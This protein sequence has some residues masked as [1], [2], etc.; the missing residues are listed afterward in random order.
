MPFWWNRRRR[1]FYPRRNW[2]KTRYY[3][4]RRKRPIRRRRRRIPRR[5]RRRR[6]RYK[7]RRKK[8]TLTVKQWQPDSIVTCKIKG[9]GCLVLGAEGKQ[10]YCY[11]TVKQQWTPAKTPGGGGFGVEVFTLKYLYEE[12]QFRHNVWTKSNLFKDLCRYLRCKFT[13]YRHQ[14][15]D[16]II[17][18]E[19]QP[20]FDLN[21]FTY[22]NMHPIN[23]LLAPHKRILLSKK[24]KPNGK[25]KISIIIKP[26]K[27]M[28]TKWFF[29]DSFSKAPL[30]LIKATAAN[31]SY[32][33]LGC[34]NENQIITFAYINTG[35]YTNPAWGK[36][37]SCD[38]KPYSTAPDSFTVKYVNGS[39][40]TVTIGK[41]KVGISEGYFQPDLLKAVQILQGATH[42]AQT[43]LN[44]ARYNVTLDTGKNNAIWLMSTLAD[45]YKKP[46]TDDIII[47]EGL[48]LYMALNGWL[49]FITTMKNTKNYLD[50]YI[51]GIQSPAIEPYAQHGTLNWYIPISQ[52]FINGTGPYGGYVS[53][54]RKNLWFPQVHSQLEVLNSI[55]EAS[56]FVPKYSQDKQSTWELHYFYQFLFKWGGPQTTDPTVADP[57]KQGHYDVPDT[58]YSS[59][60]I[61][62]PEKQTAPS[63]L[64]SWDY[65]RGFITQRALKRMSSNIQTDTTFQ[66]DSET[67]S[68]KKKRFQGPALQ[69]PDQDFQKTKSCLLSLCESDT[70]QEI[71]EN[72]DLLHLIQQQRDQQQQ[73]KRNLLHLLTELKSKQRILQMQTGFVE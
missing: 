13:F 43:P 63:I 23:M 42:T 29:T 46:T 59:V 14:H 17:A 19:R 3:R 5:R 60:Q 39:Q 73:L 10:F 15:T 34:C 49:Q 28:I 50:S 61:R 54:T 55:V 1:T 21:K 68:K 30:L 62:N 67:S 48:P 66:S 31:F 35:F 70:C 25:N 47:L 57:T 36:A 33:R 52:N 64:H 41:N 58:V 16:F 12:Y 24:N 44:F 71:P 7:V 26:P 53:D 45:T 56:A 9:M 27:Q 6:R 32:S 11:T 4:K 40:K 8:Q 65:R 38:Y 51:V 69:N 18:Y 72:Q 37:P 20:P 22:P 2:Y